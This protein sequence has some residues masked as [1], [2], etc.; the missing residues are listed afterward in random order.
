[1]QQTKGVHIPIITASLPDCRQNGA[2]LP[3]HTT[4]AVLYITHHLSPQ[5]LLGAMGGGLGTDQL[6]LGGW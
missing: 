1:M 2:K 5:Q 6:E 3:P 4:Q